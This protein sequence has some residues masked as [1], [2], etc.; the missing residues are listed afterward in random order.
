MKK[1]LLFFLLTVHASFALATET[2]AFP[3]VKKLMDEGE[4]EAAGLEKLSPAER[5]ALNQWLI[6]YTAFEAPLILR[7]NEE[8]KQVEEGFE[9]IAHIKQPFKGWTGKSVFYMDNGEVWAQRQGGQYLYTGTETAVVID[10][11]YLGFHVM[12]LTATG[13]AVG[14][15]R[16]R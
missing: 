10:K 2:G 16:V 4:Y 13:K 5:D 15:K 11:N 8:V 1:Y 14:V 3:G 12:T 7:T 6:K 9:L